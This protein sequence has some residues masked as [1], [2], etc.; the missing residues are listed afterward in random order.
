MS[1]TIPLVEKRKLLKS[2]SSIVITIPKEWLTE[3]GLDVGDEV[4]MVSNGSLKFMKINKE[5]VEN[6]RNQLNPNHAG[7]SAT[8]TEGVA[9]P[10]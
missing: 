1:R 5:N 10:S 4:M 2:G 8:S 9:T 3:N 6:V 7:A